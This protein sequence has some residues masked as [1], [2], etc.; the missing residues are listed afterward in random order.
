MIFVSRCFNDLLTKGISLVVSPTHLKVAQAHEARNYPHENADISRLFSLFRLLPVTQMD[1]GQ[2][3]HLF[4][5][6]QLKVTG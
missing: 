3:D 1:G 4:F 2:S 6:T 5:L